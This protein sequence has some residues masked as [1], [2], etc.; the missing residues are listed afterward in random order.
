MFRSPHSYRENIFHEV[1]TRKKITKYKARILEKK[2]EKIPLWILFA[3]SSKILFAT[4]ETRT[5][6]R[7]SVGANISIFTEAVSRFTAKITHFEVEIENRQ[8]SNRRHRVESMAHQMGSRRC[9]LRYVI[10]HRV[11]IVAL[12]STYETSKHFTSFHLSSFEFC[13]FEIR[14]SSFTHRIIFIWLTPHH[15]ASNSSTWFPK[16]HCVC[17]GPFKI[18]NRFC[19]RWNFAFNS[20]HAVSCHENRPNERENT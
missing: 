7:F 6:N 13:V 2:I 9:W 4:N 19:E 5:I 3:F 14:C 17:F 8:K 16:N 20:V 1:K 18:R 12:L 10:W 11:N 15:S